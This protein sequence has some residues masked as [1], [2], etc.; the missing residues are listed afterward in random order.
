MNDGLFSRRTVR[1][2]ARTMIVVF[3][4]LGAAGLF[5]ATSALLIRGGEQI[6]PHLKLLRSYLPGY[7]VTWT[8]AFIGM[9]YGALIGAA[10][11]ATLALVYNRI[12]ARKKP[13]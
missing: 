8:G 6:G 3:G 11:G 1:L 12:A 4:A 13:S 9:G 7:R 10:V 2:H 5:V